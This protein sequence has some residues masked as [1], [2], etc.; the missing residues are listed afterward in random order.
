MAGLIK[1]ISMERALHE[2]PKATVECV[3]GW[4][5]QPMTSRVAAVAQHKA[6]VADDCPIGRR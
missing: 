4:R 1:R 5:S 3:C 6:H 2:T